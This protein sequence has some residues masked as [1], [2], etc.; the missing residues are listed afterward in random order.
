[1]CVHY[2]LLHWIY[3]ME[4]EQMD[5]RV[6]LRLQWKLILR[7]AAIAFDSTLH[8]YLI[9]P[10]NLLHD[11]FSIA[12]TLLECPQIVYLF[13]WSSHVIP[14]PYWIE[15]TIKL[16]VRFGFV[17]FV[18]VRFSFLFLF[19]LFSCF[20]FSSLACQFQV[21]PSWNMEHE[22]WSM[23]FYR[24]SLCKG[25]TKT[26]TFSYRSSKFLVLM[27]KNFKIYGKILMV[28][29]ECWQ[30]PYFVFKSTKAAGYPL[31]FGVQTLMTISHFTSPIRRF[32]PSDPIPSHATS[33]ECFKG[34]YWHFAIFLPLWQLHFWFI[35]Y[36]EKIV[37]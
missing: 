34:K 10:F 11:I 3:L 8:G 5:Y 13:C 26:M 36:R 15:R 30:V 28:A 2:T 7:T 32:T 37:N 19:L 25:K 14:I 24:H 22:A 33:Y 6:W 27:Y 4:E 17:S 18:S 31:K 12:F 1:M 23:I 9:N 16:N 29:L 21:I 35:I 20:V